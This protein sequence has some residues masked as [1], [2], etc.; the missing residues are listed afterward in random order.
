M[1]AIQNILTFVGPLPPPLNGFSSVSASILKRMRDR[2]LS[3]AVSDR[4]PP[5]NVGPR[6]LLFV[7]LQV[8]LTYLCN[9]PKARGTALYLALSGANGQLIDALYLATARLLRKRIFVHHHSYAYIRN[10]TV[11]SRAV[12]RLA[13]RATHIVLSDGMGDAL[14]SKYRIEERNL[15]TVSNAAFLPAELPARSSTVRCVKP[16]QIGFLSNITFEKGFVTFF[17]VLAQLY[18]QGVPYVARIAGPV[19]ENARTIFDQRLK[20]AANVTAVGPVYG[21]DKE[22]FYRA[23]DILLFPTSYNNEAE[24]LV[25]HEALRHG[26]FV[27]ACDRGAIREI[28]GGR[29]GIVLGNAEYVASCVSLLAEVSQEPELLARSRAAARDCAA[30]LASSAQNALGHLLDEMSLPTEASKIN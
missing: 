14:S 8:F 21:D 24:P 10:P 13:H 9:G 19:A 2:G 4:S 17:D 25:V 28:L 27:I 3:V 29:G 5:E 15:R 6:R 11:V 7:H 30:R 12:L 18:A 20:L 16:L 22:T 1:K 23:L 26:V